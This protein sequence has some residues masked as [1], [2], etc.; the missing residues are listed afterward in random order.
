MEPVSISG[1]VGSLVAE[2][3]LDGLAI[4]VLLVIA[5]L[6]PSFPADATVAGRPVG[7][8]VTAILI[9]VAIAIV[10]F[11]ILLGFPSTF[12]R[13]ARRWSKVLPGNS[14]HTLAEVLEAFLVGLD[15]LR[16]PA[17]LFPAL[18]WSFVLWSWHA[19]SFWLG[20]LA[21]DLDRGY[22]AALFVQAMVAVGVSVPAAPGYF[23]TWHAAALVGLH[24]VYSVAEESTLAFAFGYHLGGFIPVTLIGL[25]FAA[26]MGMT[27]SELGKAEDTVE[28]ALDRELGS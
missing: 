18:A 24:E 19:V 10:V 7:E 28:E 25:W 2:R 12:V 13:I 6:H 8:T 23:G 15:A 20:F 16:R 14:G 22:V 21:F 17:L 5:V 4:F 9:V 11:A 26:R 1:A 27:L 3:F